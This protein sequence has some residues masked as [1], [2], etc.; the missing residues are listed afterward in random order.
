VCEWPII[1]GVKAAIYRR[2]GPPDV[3]QLEDLDKPV[4][5]DKEILV[6]VHATTVCATDSRVRKAEYFIFRLFIGLRKPRKPVVAGVEF[7]G[8]VVQVGKAVSRFKPGDLIFGWPG[9]GR[10]THVEYICMPESGA[11]E[12][13]PANMSLDEAAT[14][15]CGGMTALVFLKKAKIEAGQNV[16]VYGASGAVGV[17]AVQLA[18]YFGARVTGVC[19]PTNQALVKSLGADA[20]IDYTKDDFSHA[21]RVY[22]VIVDTVGMSGFSRSMKALK[23]GGAYVLIAGPFLPNPGRLWA[24]ITGAARIVSPFAGATVKNMGSNIVFLKELIESGKLRT[25][26]G[27]RYAFDQIAQAHAYT[28]TGHKVGSVLVVVNDVSLSGSD[29]GLS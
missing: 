21:G 14:I 16:L 29:D 10:G 18:K 26:I 8:R 7:S 19:G 25:V 17:F 23:R 28:D 15:F 11:V 2:Y 6:R 24:T 5:K 3:V 13:K 27:R 4:P 12:L 22:D 20:V 1:A 9:N